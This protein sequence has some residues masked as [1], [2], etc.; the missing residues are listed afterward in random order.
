MNAK[1]YQKLDK[2]AEQESSSDIPNH[3]IEL[4]DFNANAV[5]RGQQPLVVVNHKGTG[6]LASLT[7]IYC[8][9]YRLTSRMFR[10]FEDMKKYVN[11]ENRRLP[12][13]LGKTIILM[14]DSK[15]EP[16]L[17]VGP[18]IAMSVCLFVTIV[19]L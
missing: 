14:Y 7:G 18:H 1:R 9:D 3:D 13:V 15:G 12:R 19:V 17:T 5:A 16:L 11:I 2:Q 4:Q 6:R 8:L 10:D